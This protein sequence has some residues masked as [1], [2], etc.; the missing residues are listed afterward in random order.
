ELLL[1]TSSRRETLF[2]QLFQTDIFRQIELQLQERAKDIVTRREAN[3]LQIAGLLEQVK[4]AEETQLAAAID[5]LLPA[6]AA[7]RQN[8][9]Q[10][11]ERLQQAQRKTDE[12]RQRLAQLEQRDQVAAHLV[13][14]TQREQA[15][16]QQEAVLRQ[17][18]SAAILRPLF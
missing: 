5:E 13:V 10:A 1:E 17:A 4:V 18:R 3:E 2:A 8:R 6:E 14:L 12:A 15:I 7:A 16:A 9:Q 11:V